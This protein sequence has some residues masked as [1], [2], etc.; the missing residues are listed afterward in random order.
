[1][2]VKNFNKLIKGTFI[3]YIM[4]RGLSGKTNNFTGDLRKGKMLFLNEG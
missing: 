2:Y 1:M 4:E 3:N